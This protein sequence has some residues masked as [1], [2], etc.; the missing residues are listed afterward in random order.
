METGTVDKPGELAPE[1]KPAADFQP[2]ELGGRNVCY[3]SCSI[4]GVCYAALADSYTTETQQEQKQ[5]CCP[6]F[7]PEGTRRRQA[8]QV[9]TLT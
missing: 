5:P 1:T 4:H 2:P 7:C 8:L 9:Y 6:G 3:L